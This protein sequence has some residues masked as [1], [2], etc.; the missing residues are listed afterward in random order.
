MFELRQPGQRMRSVAA[1]HIGRWHQLPADGR[2]FWLT[3]DAAV[4]AIVQL[5]AAH[6]RWLAQWHAWNR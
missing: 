4:V 1:A 3:K 6:A 2:A 5:H